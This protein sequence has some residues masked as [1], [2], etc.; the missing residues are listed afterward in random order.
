MIHDMTMMG[1]LKRLIG[2]ALLTMLALHVPSAPGQQIDV[3]EYTLDNGM[4]FLLLPRHEEPHTI[5]AGWAARVGS[6]N[7]RPGVTG[8]THFTEHMMFK[9]TPTIGTTDPDADAAFI[10]R[11]HDIADRIN[12]IIHTTQLDR[13]LAGEID[14]PWD[15]AHDTD[16]LAKLREQLRASAEAHRAITVSSEFDRIYTNAGGVGMNAFTSNDL[17]FYYIDVPSNRFELWAW[18]ESDRLLNPVFREFHSER[19]VVREE[20]RMTL[21]S[22]P[23][24]ELNEQFDAMF[25]QSSPYS[26]SVLGW[27]SDI[28]SY[29]RAN[30]EEYFN[31]YYSANNLVGVV[32]G[33]FDPA[34]IKPVIDRYFGRLE[35]GRKPPTPVYTVEVE[36]V[37]EKR[38]IGEG[39]CP[40]QITIRYHTVP[41]NHRDSYALDICVE[42]LNGRTGRLYRALVEDAE[43][44]ASASAF[45][46]SRKYAGAFEFF[47]EVKGDASAEDLEAAWYEQLERLRTEP[48][49]DFEL[50]KIKNQVA[51]DSFRR[52]Q[53]NAALR[54]QLGYF[55]AL[56]GWEHI[57]DQAA[58][59]CAVTA[60]DIMRIANTYFD[61]S[62]RNVAIYR[63][64]PPAE[65]EANGDAFASFP[66]EIQQQVR[67][68]LL[69]LEAKDD[70][71]ELGMMLQMM[72]AQAGDAPPEFK[73][74]MEYLLKRLR[75]RIADLEAG[76]S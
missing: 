60:D 18:M 73:P 27:A 63:R 32:V 67:P 48:V 72:E 69:M 7:E 11:Q 70:P 52:L 41:F 43:I 74:V 36:Q 47:A 65:G 22:D 61:P 54:V 66:P 40:E 12:H 5:S 57:N 6:V 33:D 13:Y 53:S 75:Q 16:E 39:D 10:A 45:Q 15:P 71:A 21:E 24:G 17:T 4:L 50:R 68:F 30:F 37:A 64:R 49:S 2:A 58:K 14:N 20:R 35:R 62:N 44:A 42:I 59:L 25:W 29:S 3:E 76:G 31:T 23:T 51:T 34:E 46:D 1:A 55:E 19:D 9:G 8:I 26:W 38:L 56:G 28:E